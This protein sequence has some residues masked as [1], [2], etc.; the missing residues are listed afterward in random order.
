MILASIK[1]PEINIQLLTFRLTKAD[2]LV[3]FY[4]DVLLMSL[5]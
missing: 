5:L 2:I 4:L 1:S 3:F